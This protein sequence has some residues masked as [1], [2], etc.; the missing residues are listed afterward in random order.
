VGRLSARPVWR[1]AISVQ[2]AATE[3]P[4]MFRKR[5]CI[6]VT[7][8]ARYTVVVLLSMTSPSPGRRLAH[9]VDEVFNV[10]TAA[11]VSG[12]H[13]ANFVICGSGIVP[14]KGVCYENFAR[15]AKPAH[16]N[17]GFFIRGDDVMVFVRLAKMF[18]CYNGVIF[19]LK[20]GDE[21]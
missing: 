5:V 19:Y 7:E 10:G 18:Q 11:H 8:F 16:G 2:P 15:V 17:S 12:E 1:R 9:S 13:G 21:A 4:D 3:M 20:H 6:S 14:D